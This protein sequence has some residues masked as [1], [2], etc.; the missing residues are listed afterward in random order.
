[1]SVE[2]YTQCLDD[3]TPPELVRYAKLGLLSMAEAPQIARDR[4][5]HSLISTADRKAQFAIEHGDELGFECFCRALSM[6]R[7]KVDE[8]G[9]GNNDFLRINSR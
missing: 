6:I 8:L 9:K 3:L 7:T 4:L 2:L 1:M 5:S